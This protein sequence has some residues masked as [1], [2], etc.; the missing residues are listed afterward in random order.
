[1]LRSKVKFLQLKY[2][3]TFKK[4]ISLALFLF[5]CLFGWF[6]FFKTRFLCLTALAVLELTL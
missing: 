4:K 2:N 5:V 6:W 3:Q 1:M